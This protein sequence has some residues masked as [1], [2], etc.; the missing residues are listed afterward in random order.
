MCHGREYLCWHTSVT[1]RFSQSSASIQDSPPELVDR[2][3]HT[4]NGRLNE[5][6]DSATIKNHLRRL[7]FLQLIFCLWTSFQM[8]RIIHQHQIIWRTDWWPTSIGVDVPKDRVDFVYANQWHLMMLTAGVLASAGI[9]SRIS[10]YGIP[11]NS[12]AALT[13][14]RYTS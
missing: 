7:P 4:M 8:Q 9:F 2:R 3:R 5:R 6:Q 11:R 1:P 12:S 10:R 14:R 13:Q